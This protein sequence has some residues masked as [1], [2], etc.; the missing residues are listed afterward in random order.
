[1]GNDLCKHTSIHLLQD[2]TVVI[3]EENYIEMIAVK[4]EENIELF[5]GINGKCIGILKDIINNYN[6]TERKK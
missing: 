2:D 5:E 1:M 4:K 6:P 3:L